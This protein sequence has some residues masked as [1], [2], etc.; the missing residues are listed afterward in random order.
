MLPAPSDATP[1]RVAH[2]VT[3]I[4]IQGG[5]NA[6]PGYILLFAFTITALPSRPT[7]LVS[8]R[9]AAPGIIELPAEVLKDKSGIVVPHGTCQTPGL[10]SWL[11]AIPAKY[12]A[13]TP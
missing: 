9:K 11:P 7:G 12:A 8:V 13:T 10:S 5:S 3:E 2:T 6:R 1:S 4:S